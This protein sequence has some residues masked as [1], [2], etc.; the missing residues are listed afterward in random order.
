MDPRLSVIV[1]AYNAAHSLGLCLEAILACDY[2]DVECLVVDD[3]SR[4]ATADCARRYPV[5]LL[6]LVDGPRGPAYARN[7]AAEVATGDIL[8]FIDADVVVHRDTLSRLAASFHGDPQVGAVF[9]SYDARPAARNF[10]SQYRNL[11]HHF[12]HQQG[13]ETASTFWAGCGAVRRDVF[14][15]VGGFDAHRYP[16]P[17][18]EDIEL[19]YRLRAAGYTIVLNK[20][21]QAQHLKVWTVRSM[22][23]TDVLDRAIPWTRLN[24]EAR[25]MPDD[26]NLRLS[27]RIAALLPCL[28]VVYLAA[29]PLTRPTWQWLVVPLLLALGLVVALNLPF[30]RFFARQRGILFAV[31]VIP[32]HLLYYLYSVA[33]F[34]V[35]AG[36][37]LAAR[38]APA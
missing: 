15:A 7:Y 28:A 33:A 5:R 6:S 13:R 25:A 10:V 27:Q 22:L 12:V 3:S 19:G 37:H 36:L 21:A 34:A 8:V 24:L 17:S 2:P 26:L 23:K 38:R 14:L 9:G 30:Y 20:A 31:E 16:R 35:G 18:I 32:F 11:F 1:P 4:D 29:L